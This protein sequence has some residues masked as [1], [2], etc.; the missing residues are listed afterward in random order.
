MIFRSPTIHLFL[1]DQVS[2]FDVNKLIK[3]YRF[4]IYSI[5][6]FFEEGNGGVQETKSSEQYLIITKC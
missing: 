4:S 5:Y 3:L 6:I 2:T 1:V